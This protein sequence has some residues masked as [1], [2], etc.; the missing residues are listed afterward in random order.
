MLE[1]ISISRSRSD[2]G[3]GDDG[4]DVMIYKF[5]TKPGVL[6]RPIARAILKKPFLPGVPFFVILYL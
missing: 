3:D 4:G 5:P 2:G 6:L 1:S